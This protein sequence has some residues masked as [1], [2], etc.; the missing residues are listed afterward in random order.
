MLGVTVELDGVPVGGAEIYSNA[1]STHRALV[2]SYIPVKLTLD[3]HTVTLL[4]TN[5]ATVSDA[6]DLFNLVLM[7]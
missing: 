6:N 4:P 5:S 7:F 3:K 2:S 1:A